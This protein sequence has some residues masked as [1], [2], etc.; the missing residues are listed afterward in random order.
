VLVVIV[1]VILA[2]FLTVHVLFNHLPIAT[3]NFLF[4]RINFLQSMHNLYTAAN[5]LFLLARFS[6]MCK[7]KETFVT[8]S[9]MHHLLKSIR[10]QEK[11]IY[12]VLFS[13]PVRIINYNPG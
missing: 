1:V 7:Y 13:L 4:M 2:A 5:L 9:G 8:T 3:A 11:C 6:E 12:F 10:K